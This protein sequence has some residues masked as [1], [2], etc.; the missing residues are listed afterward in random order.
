MKIL[1]L[2]MFLRKMRSFS[3]KPLLAATHDAMY[4]VGAAP[5]NAIH[6]IMGADKCLK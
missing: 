3:E 2:L 6:D 1:L 4:T 5:I